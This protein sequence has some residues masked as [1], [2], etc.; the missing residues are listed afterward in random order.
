MHAAQREPRMRWLSNRR[1]TRS[2]LWWAP[3]G[4]DW[5]G[6]VAP[7]WAR[8]LTGARE[9]DAHDGMSRLHEE[10]FRLNV[11]LQELARVHGAKGKVGHHDEACSNPGRQLPKWKE[12]PVTHGGRERPRSPVRG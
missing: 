11:R 7:D 9:N 12:G 6:T 1:L 2:I 4:G 3:I 8:V 5:S 10:G